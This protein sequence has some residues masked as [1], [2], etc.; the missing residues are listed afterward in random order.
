MFYA[1]YTFAL[2]SGGVDLH[3]VAVGAR[4]AVEDY[5]RRKVAPPGHPDVEIA[6]IAD[7]LI[8]AIPNKTGLSRGD[9]FPAFYS[10]LAEPGWPFVGLRLDNNMNVEVYYKPADANSS[11]YSLF[12]V[13]A[14]TEIANSQTGD[15]R[16][17][18]PTYTGY[19]WDAASPDTKIM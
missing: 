9:G 2:T 12:D 6:K 7:R 8:A 15:L 17:D 11:P 13:G 1:V 3:L 14:Q 19:V 10:A 5:I 16:R 4:P 18:C